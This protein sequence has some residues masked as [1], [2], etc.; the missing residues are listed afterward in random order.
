[1]NNTAAQGV[2]F[3]RPLCP[4]PERAEYSGSGD[5]KDASN[6]QCVA[7]IVPIDTRNVGPQKAYK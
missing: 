5:P 2:E 3:Q 6:F 4:F 1:V 7:R